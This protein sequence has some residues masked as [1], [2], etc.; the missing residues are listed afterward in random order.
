MNGPVEQTGGINWSGLLVCPW[1]IMCLSH[2]H[3]LLE[4]ICPGADGNG[5]FSVP[6]ISVVIPSWAWNQGD[7]R[8]SDR[9]TEHYT[10]RDG[11]GL[12]QARGSARA[13]LK[14]M[15][16]VSASCRLCGLVASKSAALSSLCPPLSHPSRPA[17]RH[18]EMVA[19]WPS[20]RD[21]TG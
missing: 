3:H 2:E 6:A 7:V 21:T 10:R 5:N 20:I 8:L 15:L 11:A 19:G 13:L 14:R 9:A 4:P 17:D 16:R 18:G 1:N 12:E